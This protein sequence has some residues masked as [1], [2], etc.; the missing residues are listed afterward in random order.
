MV[1]C[2]NRVAPLRV[3]LLMKYL[4]LYI[5]ETC[6]ELCVCACAR[7]RIYVHFWMYLCI[8]CMKLCIYTFVVDE[9]RKVHFHTGKCCFS[10]C[11]LQY[12]FVCR[13]SHLTQWFCILYFPIVCN[14]VGI[15]YNY[16]SMQLIYNSFLM[17]SNLIEVFSIKM[18]WCSTFMSS[19]TLL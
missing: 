9:S 13:R 16:L 5:Y 2:F 10:V 19:P 4:Y 6:K 3:L 12:T 8:D 15:T 1:F 11:V 7:A 18:N 14:L 17:Y